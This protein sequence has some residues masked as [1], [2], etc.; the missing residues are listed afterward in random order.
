MYL[1]TGSM[2]P[3]LF[4][5][6]IFLY[7]LIKSYRLY[8]GDDQKLKDYVKLSLAISLI[9]L[10]DPRF[11]IW[12][13]IGFTGL[14][15][16]SIIVRK[17]FIRSLKILVYPIII[18]LPIILF[19]YYVWVMGSFSFVYVSPRPLTF[20][21]IDS[22]SKSFPLY[23]YFQ[24]LGMCWPAFIYSPPS[25][26]TFKGN[27]N[28]LITIGH[29]TAMIYPYD[30]LGYIWFALTFSWLFFAIISML[31]FVRKNE[32]VHIIGFILLFIFTI[33]TYFPIR[34]FI[35]W[36]ISLGR[37]PV[38]GGIWGIT[39]AIPNYFMWAVYPYVIFYVSLIFVRLLSNDDI[40]YIS[41][42]RHR[43]FKFL[44][45]MKIN[46][47]NKKI[48]A[49]VI[50]I[51][52][53]VPNWQFFG[54]IYPGQ[55]TPVIP[56]N[57]I[58]SIGPLQP[59]KMPGD[60]QKIYDY[61]SSNYDGS[62]NIVW[63]QAWGFAF[64]WSPRV[65]PWYQPG[66]SP[67]S[68]FFTYL[69]DIVNKKETYMLKPLMDIYGI[70][71]FVIDNYS[72]LN[73]NPLLPQLTNSQLV[74]FF[75]NSPGIKIFL[76]DS[77]NI[78]VF[79]DPGASILQGYSSAYSIGNLSPLY[80]AYYF[81]YIKNITPLLFKNS[82]PNLLI[83]DLNINNN[84][85]LF[86]YDFFSKM[87]KNASL[88]ENN[89]DYSYLKGIYYLGNNW[90]FESLKG[91]GTLDIGNG[92]VLLNSSQNNAVQL[93]YG[94]FLSPGH[95]AIYIP[96]GY[97]VN[98]TVSY[99]F[100]GDKNSSSGTSVWVTD[101]NYTKHGGWYLTG[102]SFKGTGNFRHVA[103]NATIPPGYM[104]FE[105]QINS[106]FIGSVII[107]NISISYSFF[108]II[109]NHPFGIIPEFINY[110]R[111]VN[112][113]KA[114]MN[115]SK[116]INYSYLKGIYYLGNNWYF[117]SLKGNGTLDIGNGTVLLNSSQNNAVQL[118]YGNFL[119]PGHTA[120]YI[121]AGYG[122]NLT[123][124]YDFLGDK[125]SSSGT[126]VWVTDGNYTKHGGWYL[127]GNSFKGTGNFRHVALNATIP[128]GY[129]YF[130]VQINSNFIGSV[131]IKNISIS[132][133]FFKIMQEKYYLIKNFKV[134]GNEN[135]SISFAYYGNG[136]LEINN[137]R[138]YL[139]SSGDIMKFDR[140]IFIN[141]SV[142]KMKVFNLSIGGMIITPGELSYNN[143]NIYYKN[144]E[145]LPAKVNFVNNGSKFMSVS[146][147][148]YDWGIE[149]GKFIGFDAFGR[150]IFILND[151][152]N[153]YIYVKNVFITNIIEIIFLI[154]FYSIL[155]L[156]FIPAN[157]F[158]YIWGIL[159]KFKKIKLK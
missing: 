146:T 23:S 77:P 124:S 39:D 131:I 147:R 130:E 36:Y 154:L 13:F 149:K 60:V 66:S 104:Y 110:Q 4:G 79:E 26:L 145:Y 156:I 111:P 44:S 120:I 126:S 22:Y 63:P 121:P 6:P 69:N 19:I 16:F 74:E 138:Y 20:S 152:A 47:K 94:N 117:E 76:N 134:S 135:Y 91:N 113:S 59:V 127:T 37:L 72:Y 17:N 151:S 50:L 14:I 119:S 21:Y 107:K 8:N 144:Y 61:L 27:I 159:M 153:N 158:E 87:N 90:Y 108:K 97:G 82:T 2:L 128:P 143:S 95:T 70:R 85:A 139:N 136:T 64:K 89:F 106:N 88:I 51:L 142:I 7:I 150:E 41:I 12:T 133:S 115:I 62:Y 86:T 123:V 71:Y 56:G 118:S 122:V 73:K 67:P 3:G 84:S 116:F 102:N 15:I 43:N 55:Y 92:T 105:V 29:P 48:F 24:L 103:L 25:I 5:I 45:K 40:K 30:I 49:V 78:W 1:F 9:S 80:V 53:I 46:T 54:N 81:S 75:E 125:N 83:N 35:D 68:Q 65:T 157:R 132:Y 99:D 34:Q 42:E 109:N 112:Y 33:G 57:G 137:E 100:L 141:C 93:S 10:G 98:L 38:V 140:N 101:G 52:L 32:R 58:S 114:N 96:A 11:F 31:F 155:I 148:S 28:N 129:M 18:S